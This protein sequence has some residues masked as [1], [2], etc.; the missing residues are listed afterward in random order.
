MQN[1]TEQAL[2][3]YQFHRDDPPFDPDGMCLKVCRTARNIPAKYASAKEAQDATPKEHRV[4]NIADIRRGMVMYF[5]TV[6]DSNPFGHIVTVAGRVKGAD[7]DSL[8]SI[9]VWTNSVVANKL[10]AV[11]ASYFGQHWADKFQFAATWL[12]G[13]EL[14]FPEPKK[15]RRVH[16]VHA[17]LQVQDTTEQI[18][19]DVN[20]LFKREAER[21]VAIIA[22]TEAFGPRVT[23]LL[24]TAGDAHGYRV[25]K[26]AG[27]DC[28][29]AVRKS[30][31][32]GNFGVHWTK[33]I[34]G[35]DDHRD[36]GVFAVEFDTDHLGHFTVLAQHLLTARQENAER[37]NNRV[38][39]ASTIY[40][41]QQGAGS[42]KVLYFGDQNRN[43]KVSDTFRGRPFTSLGDELDRH[44]AT[45]AHGHDI[46][47]IA[48]YNPDKKVIAAYLRVLDDKEFPQHGDHFV[49]EGG[50]D[51]EEE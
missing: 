23:D 21:R 1:T 32:A 18:R 41:E 7:R 39:A 2:Q 13:Q 51:V 3:W 16:L 44:E 17:S 11:R 30:F 31:I 29:I 49:V 28:W 40:A 37:K 36:L 35:N 6:G 25:E 10:V 4:T 47:V 15:T 27:Q 34:E 5:D 26:P 50:I 8:D 14:L 46:D 24:E 43:D 38:L 9:I 19:S 42:G 12:N 45:H 20:D 48:T 22:G 33:V